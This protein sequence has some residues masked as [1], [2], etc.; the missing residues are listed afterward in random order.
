MCFLWWNLSGPGRAQSYVRLVPRYLRKFLWAFNCYHCIVLY[1]MA[2]NI[3]INN[4]SIKQNI[5]F[6]VGAKKCR[7]LWF[8][9]LLSYILLIPDCY[10]FSIWYR[11][12]SIK[13]RL[14]VWRTRRFQLSFS[15]SVSFP[16]PISISVI[17]QSHFSVISQSQKKKCK[18]K[19]KFHININRICSVSIDYPSYFRFTLVKLINVYIPPLRNQVEI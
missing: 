17:S 12:I 9:L 5:G 6:L 19:C 18:F 2:F 7:K 13:K 8:I 14:R 10:N 11:H 16:N 1:C 4:T 15:I 3:H